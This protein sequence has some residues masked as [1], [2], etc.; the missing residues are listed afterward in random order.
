MGLQ[1]CISKQSILITEL[2][3][4]RFQALRNMI[5]HNVRKNFTN[6]T[7]VALHTMRNAGNQA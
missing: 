6:I 4:F 7:D 1:G 2:C 5:I 3:N